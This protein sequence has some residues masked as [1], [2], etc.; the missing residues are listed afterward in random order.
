MGPT[1]EMNPLMGGL[2]RE[3]ILAVISRL[4]EVQR[5]WSED[6]GGGNRGNRATEVLDAVLSDLEEALETGSG[7]M[8][9]EDVDLGLAMVE[10]MFEA[11]GSQSFSRVI[12]SIRG[13]LIQPGVELADKE[14]PPPPVRFQPPSSAAVR[15]R[16]PRPPARDHRVVAPAPPRKGR[17]GWFII[18]VFIIAAVGFVAFLRDQEGR[19]VGRGTDST[20]PVIGDRPLVSGM[21]V[22]SPPVEPD[23]RPWEEEEFDVRE[24]EMA[25]LTLEVRL[26]EEA[27]GD[28]DLN[29]ALRHFAA[30]ATIDRQHPRVVLTGK[31]LIACMMRAGDLAHGAGDAELAAKRFESA[32]SLVRGLGLEGG[33]TRPDSTEFGFTDID[34]TEGG[35]LQRIVGFPVRLTLKTGDVVYGRAGGV[36]GD[37][38]QLEI[39]AGT[40]AGNAEESKTILASTIKSIRV[41]S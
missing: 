4:R 9:A 20:D 17:F 15:R 16:R 36:D 39:Y 30:A 31:Y 19:P 3:T 10:D 6:Q 5:R 7:S 26:A 8:A 25:S 22:L 32:R 38:L 27:M 35:A 13:S 21:P 40:M 11:E 1:E 12:A 2:D 18:A 37:H 24:E 14:E 23:R 29:G 28:G 33:S 34:P 41:Y